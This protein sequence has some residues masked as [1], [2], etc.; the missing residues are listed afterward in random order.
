MVAVVTVLI[1]RRPPRSVA[2]AGPPAIPL[3][4]LVRFAAIDH[5]AALV[6]LGTADVLTLMVLQEL[7]PEA[8]AYY[9]MANTISYGLFLVTSN[10]SSAL[11]AEGA[12]SPDRV[13][14]LTRAALRNSALLVLPAAGLGVLLARPVLS[15]F[16][17]GYA[18]HGY[19]SAAAAPALRRPAGRDRSRARGGPPS[20]RPA[21]HRPHL[22]RGGGHHLRRVLGR[23]ESRRPERCGGGVPGQPDHGRRPAAADRTVGPV[24]GSTRM[25][26][27]A[28]GASSG[29][30]SGCGAPGAAARPGAGWPPRSKPAAWRRPAEHRLLTSD[31]DVLVVALDCPPEALVVKIA[32]SPAASAGLDRHADLLGWLGPELGGS[33]SAALLPR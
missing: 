12:R 25:A 7:G 26:R 14:A 18:D 22:Q 32:T 29:F 30:R 6:W 17:S 27:A 21:D 23:G 11:V 9:F 5:V 33:P 8:S 16:G 15:L 24:A 28:V 3:G 31:S 4:R 19:G 1:L 20:P 10:V 13:A 2:D